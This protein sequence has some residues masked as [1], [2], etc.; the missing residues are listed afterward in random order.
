MG[1]RRNRAFTL[2]ELLTALMI[3]A[4]IL[5]A[6]AAMASAVSNGKAALERNQMDISYLST[7]QYRIAD[8]VRRA[9]TILPIANGVQLQYGNGQIIAIYKDALEQ[10]WVEDAAAG[11][12]V[13]KHQK[14]ASIEQKSP[15]RI[16]IKLVIEKS[17]RPMPYRFT[18]CR[19]AGQ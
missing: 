8:A 9:E 1:H 7:L 11:M 17:G 12:M 4:I 14:V 16:E 6:A 10:I 19:Y 13:F 5:A 3:G 15:K 18:V 2:V